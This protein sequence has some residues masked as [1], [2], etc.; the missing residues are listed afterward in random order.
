MARNRATVGKGVSRMPVHGEAQGAFAH[1]LARH[2]GDLL[3]LFRRCLLLD[4]AF[5]HDVEAG[6][7]VAHQA[8]DIDHGAKALDGVE[9]AAV[10]LPVPRQAREDGVLRNV[11]HRL[12]HA[13]EEFAVFAA[14]GREGDAAVAE[15]GGGDTMPGDR[16]H[17][18]IP[19]D[20]G[21]EVRVQID[22]ARRDGLPAGVDFLAPVAGNFAHGGDGVAIDGNV[23]FERRAA[24]A[25]DDDTVAN[26]EIVRQGCLPLKKSVGG[27][28][29][30]RRWRKVKRLGEGAIEVCGAASPIPKGE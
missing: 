13:G 5:A 10:G 27:E 1:G 8:A 22:E 16:G 28:S 29:L 30:R 17:V 9:V 7:A 26:Y 3:D 21:V 15:Q 11:L 4:G 25:I 23:A 24:G 2:L 20:L 6:G 18:R 19:A 14:A 12:H